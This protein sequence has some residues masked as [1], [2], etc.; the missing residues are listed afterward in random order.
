MGVSYANRSDV[1]G[2]GVPRGALVRPSR[3][4]ARADASTN[5]IELEGHGLADDDPVSFQVVGNGA[6]PAPLAIGT[7]YFAKVVDE[8]HFQVAATEGGAAIDLSSA[9]TLPFSLVVPVGPMIDKYNEI[10]SR[11]VD[12][13]CV[14]HVVPFVAPYPSEVVNIV[15]LRTAIKVTTVLGRS[16]P[17]LERQIADEMADFLSFAS[18]PLRDARA[19]APANTAI[20]RSAA[21]AAGRARGTIP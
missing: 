17:T 10:Y 3:E 16:M 5:A 8:D 15:A 18:T 14:A 7:T 19:T 20:A 12:R 1:M 11:W 9:G 13:K 6:L 21:D 2:T 4:I